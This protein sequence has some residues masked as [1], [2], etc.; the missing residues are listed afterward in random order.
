MNI[1]V[2]TDFLSGQGCPQAA[3]RAIAE[4]NDGRGFG[5]NRIAL[6]DIVVKKP[7]LIHY[8]V[9]TVP[10]LT[11]HTWLGQ[12][13]SACDFELKRIDDKK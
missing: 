13:F 5:W 1:A 10:S 3:L 12:W 7:T 9:S 8:G 4:A 2:N 11:G 6:P